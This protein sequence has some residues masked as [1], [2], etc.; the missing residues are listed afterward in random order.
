MAKLILNVD[1][2]NFEDISLCDQL[3]I[4]RDDIDDELKKQGAMLAVHQESGD[5]FETPGIWFSVLRISD[6]GDNVFVET[7]LTI[8]EAR[9]MHAFL[10]MLLNS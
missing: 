9:Q 3:N 5:G 8:E 6:K 2:V 7:K 4:E 1:T 10:G